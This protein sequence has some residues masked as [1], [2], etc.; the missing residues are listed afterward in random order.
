MNSKKKLMKL[1]LGLGL[2]VTSALALLPISGNTSLDI[3]NETAFQQ[4]NDYIDD[5]K[6]NDNNFWTSKYRMSLKSDWDGNK[7]PGINTDLN[8]LDSDVALY[9]LDNR[10]DMTALPFGWSVKDSNN[11][12]DVNSWWKRADVQS[13]KTSKRF[14]ARFNQWNESKNGNYFSSAIYFS[15]DMVLTGTVTISLRSIDNPDVIYDRVSRNIHETYVTDN[16]NINPYMSG[17]Y[18][19]SSKSLPTDRPTLRESH[20]VQNY[21]QIPNI[22]P[23]QYDRKNNSFNLPL[24]H[25]RYANKSE[26]GI[27]HKFLDW[28]GSVTWYDKNN[29]GSN[30]TQGSED[31]SGWGPISKDGGAA[32][33]MFTD[34]GGEYLKYFLEVEFELKPNIYFDGTVSS[35]F[36]S[37]GQSFLGLGTT[38]REKGWWGD[39]FWASGLIRHSQRTQSTNLKY[40]TRESMANNEYVQDTDIIPQSTFKLFRT[41]NKDAGQVVIDRSNLFKADTPL[42]SKRS[43][44]TK[45]S[46]ILTGSGWSN[47][48]ISLEVSLDNPE[49]KKNW[50]AV[51]S[52]EFVPSATS[53]YMER[54]VTWDYSDYR[55]VKI[56]IEK[57]KWLTSLQKSHLTT[58]LEKQVDQDYN[59]PG[60]TGKRNLNEWIAYVKTYNDLQ[61]QIEEKFFETVNYASSDDELTVDGYEGTK[62][63]DYLFSTSDYKNNIDSSKFSYWQ[64]AA[65]KSDD[66][67]RSEKLF[68]RSN[69]PITVNYRNLE[70]TLANW[71]R[72]NLGAPN[73][74]E[75]LKALEDKINNYAVI[76]NS[77]YNKQQIKTFIKNIKTKALNN[78]V[79]IQVKDDQG[80]SSTTLANAWRNNWKYDYL[81]EVQKLEKAVILANDIYTKTKTFNQELNTIKITDLF[82]GGNSLTDKNPTNNSFVWYGETAREKFTNVN[83]PAWT[84]L[85]DQLIGSDQENNKANNV[86]ASE[87]NLLNANLK[88]NYLIG[89]KNLVSSLDNIFGNG[90]KLAEEFKQYNYIDAK[91]YYDVAN[92]DTNLKD[93]FGKISKIKVGGN[94]FGNR[95]NF[96]TNSNQEFVLLKP[97]QN[98]INNY[99]LQISNTVYKESAN[100]VKTK[101]N[102]L[103]NLSDAQKQSFNGEIDKLIDT[104]SATNKLNVVYKNDSDFTKT[105]ELAKEQDRINAIAKSLATTENKFGYDQANNQTK[106]NTLVKDA[107]LAEFYLGESL[108]DA[109]VEI[110]SITQTEQL[111]DSGSAKL[112]YVVKSTKKLYSTTIQSDETTSNWITG[113]AADRAQEKQRIDALSVTFALKTPKSVLAREITKENFTQYI[114][115]NGINDQTEE[116]VLKDKSFVVNDKTGTLKFDYVIR[117]KRINGLETDKIQETVNNFKTEVDRLNDVVAKIKN[118]TLTVTNNSINDKAN[119]LPSEV[120]DNEI[121]FADINNQNA[122]VKIID[123]T[124]NDDNGTLTI[125]YALT[126]TVEGLKVVQS[127]EQNSLTVNGFLTTLEKKRREVLQLINDSK[128]LNEKEKT[129]F[130]NKTNESTQT[131]QSLDELATKV[132][133]HDLSNTVKTTYTNLNNNQVEDIINKMREK[134]V[135]DDA[136]LL[137]NDASELDDAMSELHD[138]VLEQLKVLTNN[139]NI[140]DDQDNSAKTAIN[141]TLADTDKNKNYNDALLKAQNLL[142]KTSGENKDLATINT[143]IQNLTNTYNELNGEANKQKFFKTV[144][145]QT[146]LSEAQKNDY[147]TLIVNS[148][149]F[150]DANAYTNITISLN[151]AYQKL[152]DKIA[153]TKR[154]KSD[155]LYSEDTEERQKNFDAAIKA[156]EDFLTGLK[157]TRITKENEANFSSESKAKIETKIKELESA[158]SNLDGYRNK[159]KKAIDNSLYLTNVENYKDKI[160]REFPTYPNKPT[161]EQWS[162]LLGEAFN[163]SK[164]NVKNKIV[165]YNLLTTTEKNSLKGQVNSQSINTTA[166]KHF[167]ENLTSVLNTAAE[168]QKIKKDAID[169]IDNLSNLTQNQKNSFIETIKQQDSANANATKLQAEQLNQ[170]IADAKTVIL[171]EAKVLTQNDQ[172]T[173]EN[174]SGAEKTASLYKFAD[175]DKKQDYDQKVTALI[176]QMG[177][178]NASV[179]NINNAKTNLIA[180]YNALNGQ[181]NL[182]TQNTEINKLKKLSPKQKLAIKDK[183]AKSVN[184]TDLE[185]IVNK[186][187]TLDGKIAALEAKIAGAEAKKTDGIYTKDTEG[188]QAAFDQAIA[189]AESALNRY[190]TKDLA[191]LGASELNAQSVAIISDIDTLDSE[192]NKLDGYKNELKKSL[193]NWELLTETKIKELQ[194]KVDGISEKQPSEET[195]ERIL[196]EGLS[197]SKQKAK[198]DLNVDNYPNL[199]TAELTKLNEAVDSAKLDKTADHKYDSAVKAVLDNAKTQNDTK[200]NAINEINKLNFLTSDQKQVFVKKVKDNTSDQANNIL[201]EAKGINDAIRDAQKAVID[202]INELTFSDLTFE[203]AKTAK[204]T[205]DKYRLSSDKAKQDFDN[206][207]G[208]IYELVV[209]TTA[210]KEQINSAKST[211]ES[212]FAA[213]DGHLKSNEQKQVINNLSNLSEDQKKAL[214][215]KI[216]NATTVDEANAI[217]EAAKNLDKA[218]ADLKAKIAEA[219]GKKDKI[220]YTGDTTANQGKFNQAIQDAKSALDTYETVDL[221][222]LTKDQITEKAGEINTQTS[223]LNDAIGALDGYRNKFKE[224]LNNWELLDAS[225][226]KT[227]QDKVDKLQKQPTQEEKSSILQEGLSLSKSKASNKINKNNYANLS[228]EEITELL[229]KV[230][231][232]SLDETQSH[233]YDAAVKAVIKEAE[234]LNQNK[235]AAINA[236]N[237]LSDLTKN[238]K[239]VFENQVK[240]L[241]TSQASTVQETA[242]TLN[243]AILEAKNVVKEQ[244]QKLAK[245]DQLTYE[246]AKSANKVADKYRLADTALKQTYDEKLQAL[247]NLITKGNVSKTEIDN[248]KGEL[249]SAYDALNGESKAK[250]KKD[251]IDDLDNLT[252]D[253]KQALKDKIDSS[254]NQEEANKIIEVAKN[255][256]KAITDLKAKITEA[257][258]KKNDSEY[259]NDTAENKAKFDEAI[260]TAK[261]ALKSYETADLSNLNKDQIAEKTGE[262]NT[263]TS[264]LN[265]AI[266]ALDGYRNK[267]KEDLNNWAL[268]EQEDVKKLQDKVAQLDKQPTTEQKAALLKEGLD[269]SKEIATNKINKTNYGNLSDTEINDLL[270]KVKNAALDETADH[271]FDANVNDIVLKADDLQQTKAN[272]ISAIENLSDLTAEQKAE[273]TKQIKATPVSQASTIQNTANE[274]NE[275]I[276]QA[277]EAVTNQIKVLANNNQL[278]YETAKSANKVADKY[279]LADS[280]LKATY[281]EKLQALNDLIVKDNVPKTEIDNAKA[282]LVTAYEA[283][284]GN[285]KAKE[286]K[287]AIKKLNNLTLKQKE[288]LKEKIDNASDQETA[289]QI[290]EKAK[291]LDQ[292][293]SDLKT[294]L[295]EAKNTKEQPV[296]LN[297]TTTNKEALDNQITATEKLL[298]DLESFDLATN[299]NDQIIAKTTEVKKQKES[300]NTAI[301]N[302]DGK[303][304]AL[305]NEINAYAPELLDNKQDY[306]DRIN[307]LDKNNWDEEAAN[308]ILNNSLNKAKENAQNQIDALTN[309]T[310]EEKAAFKQQI[311]DAQKSASNQPVSNISAILNEAKAQNNTKQAAIDHIKGLNNLNDDQKAALVQEVKAAASSEAETLKTK[312]NELNT[313]MKNT[314][315]KVL[316]ELQTLTE[317]S[318]LEL[319]D[320]AYSADKTLDNYQ[321]ASS[322]VKVNYDAKLAKIKELLSQNTDK[323]TIDQA[324]KELE[325]AYNALNGEENKNKKAAEVDKLDNLSK[326][327]KDKIKDLLSN[328]TD[329]EAA[330]KIL[331]KAQKLNLDLGD[332]EKQ[333]T[334]TKAKVAT[335]IYTNDAQDRKEAVDQALKNAKDK[336]AELKAKDLSNATADS[337]NGLANEANQSKEALKTA[338]EALDGN[339]EVL[340]NDIN[341]HFPSLN[342]NQKGLLKAEIEK[343]PK[344]PTQEETQAVYDKALKYAQTNAKDELAKLDNLTKAEKDTYIAKIEATTLDKTNEDFAINVKNLLDQA[345]TDETAKAQAIKTINNLTNLNP[346]QKSSLTEE[347]KNNQASE[348]NNIVEKAKAI[349]NKMKAYK[350]IAEVDKT[351]VDYVEADEDRQVKYNNQVAIRAED[352]GDNG[353]NL[354]VEQIDTKITELNNAI[355]GLNGEEKV[356][357]AKENAIAKING[358]NSIYTNLTAQQKDEAI[359]KINEQNSVADVNSVD[360]NNA[361]VNGTMATL[362]QYLSNET[363]IKSD[364]NYTGSEEDLR[365]AYDD[366]IKALKDYESALNEPSDDTKD[367]LNN[368]KIAE[369]INVV[370]EAINNLNGKEH[371]KTVR[372]EEIAKINA[373]KNINDAQKSALIAKVDKATTPE[374]VRAVTEEAQALDEKMAELKQAVADK[375]DTPNSVDYKNATE[376]KMREFDKAFNNASNLADKE[377]GSAELSI[378]NIDSLI[379]KLNV[380]AQNLDGD[381][382]I[383]NK[384]AEAKNVINSLEHLNDAQKTALIEEVDKAKLLANVDKVVDK[385]QTL[386]NAMGQLKETAKAI[387]DELTQP[388]NP[389]YVAASQE[390]KANY[391]EAKTKVDQLISKQGSNE[392]VA[393]VLELEKAL[394]DA[395]NALDG[396]KNFEYAK[397]KAI[398]KVNKN[399]NLSPAEKQVLIDQV[400]DLAIPSNSDNADEVQN[401]KDNLDK[402]VNKTNLINDVKNNPNLTLE[403]KADLIDDIQKANVDDKLNKE[404]NKN[405]Y[406]D[407]LDNI[408]AK[409]TAYER[410]NATDDS[411]LNTEDKA[412]LSDNI[413]QLDPR[414]KTFADQLA[415]E[416][417]KENKIKEIRSNP[418]LT[419]DQKSQLIDEVANLDNKQDDLE[420][421]IANIDQKAK[422]IEKIQTNEHISDEDK[423]KLVNEVINVPHDDSKLTDK[424]N[425]IES[426]L[427]LIDQIKQNPKLDENTKEALIDQVH[428]LAKDSDNFATEADNISAKVKAIEQIKAN[429][430]LTKENKA[431]LVNEIIDLDNNQTKSSLDH[432]IS[433]VD[434]KAA[435]YEQINQSDLPQAQKDALIAELDPINANSENALVS[436]DNIKDQLNKLSKINN[437]QSLSDNDKAKLV[438]DVLA[439]N[440]TEQNYNEIA[441]NID[442]KQEAIDQIRQN[443][444]LTQEQKDSISQNIRELDETSE[445]FT[446]KLDNEKARL[447]LIDQLHQEA[448]DNK[449]SDE[450]RDKLIS[451]TLNLAND[452]SFVNNLNNVKTKDKLIQQVKESD[453][454]NDTTKSTLINNILDN[455]ATS[456]EF[457]NKHNQITQLYVDAEELAKAKNDLV[458]LTKSKKFEKLTKAKQDAIN[459]AITDSDEIL[460]NLNSHNNEDVVKQTTIDKRLKEASPILI[461][462]YIVAVSAVTWLI[463]M[464]IFV[465]GRK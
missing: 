101:I 333:I 445:E 351:S 357:Q 452:S 319:N 14:I 77:E 261:K 293:I 340:R 266:V 184:L 453:M 428:N 54:S 61:K 397:E 359:A 85:M 412:K 463:G 450:T 36:N 258:S 25:N 234:Q 457:D 148:Q 253:Q 6:Y 289:N 382:K 402:I 437:D 158:V 179:D 440:P 193:K 350:D 33:F 80:Q 327:Q 414:D 322:D 278:T 17:T 291:Q 159:L 349:D 195:K 190:K 449:I 379:E 139:Q 44:N 354:S 287:S 446:N 267:F 176:N 233:K 75:N 56:E 393:K 356:D 244:I 269:K 300:L 248:A 334:S 384:K 70:L 197:L 201:E 390:P 301:T 68:D 392:D 224:D 13:N 369:K 213:L 324:L 345:K 86:F 212:A 40:I 419:D 372:A 64:Y 7:Y 247:N 363:K 65:Y 380:A 20:Y 241:P 304:E 407:T 292:A 130:R 112:T 417:L 174:V 229:R 146:N 275:A 404:A 235:Q 396:D 43:F 41:D 296:Y 317:N 360:A 113:F 352:L 312:A 353:T 251:V 136:Q 375:Q 133:I 196:G 210:T 53:G 316:E 285:E 115:V 122:K 62:K 74:L 182:D 464:L 105:L 45:N 305:R 47:R 220:E 192:I 84:K 134:T 205:A 15:R 81:G 203:Q 106:S 442:K 116:I 286:Q 378:E 48:N 71:N 252:P 204:K 198:S 202:E 225:E 310:N 365:K 441:K 308:A 145:S 256:D 183:M 138:K 83:E 120:K 254:T 142:N 72:V 111:T 370:H 97:Y 226:I 200:Q 141:Y 132:K 21:Q 98:D 206:A 108:T 207:M 110:K 438:E 239:T 376:V 279:R 455:N 284:N 22:F 383:N 8:S 73:G 421:Q 186:A 160:E 444:N 215:D 272:A 342:E 331:E 302:L 447:D 433:N 413:S 35:D 5:N 368:N 355:N 448:K 219:E 274:L 238:Q 338:D 257:E 82:T 178:H 87:T 63:L 228:S 358:E 163:E 398:E 395:K 245:D 381:E 230:N 346:A 31:N 96:A 321:F 19:S 91:K 191:N 343:L 199:S 435:L 150:N 24:V 458:D 262:I 223:T 78:F 387:N 265:D 167:D 231:S 100:V 462:P 259:I 168:K 38:I 332:L 107:Q 315:D 185:D 67:N 217:V 337:L 288:Q 218:I 37:G 313:S 227:L 125:N 95:H 264:T 194:T 371:I 149:N 386:N 131:I 188:K 34:K 298:K 222:N 391:D 388:D 330:Q 60:G 216:D 416:E 328:A 66:F 166:S 281:D 325:K 366:A 18:R 173:Y 94:Q 26:Y 128:N 10:G 23:S 11:S 51:F 399:N 32:L 361:L 90:G 162:Q 28:E 117:S 409:E 432:Q 4:I 3:S 9:E 460:N 294:K 299:S 270:E 283:L 214:K 335:S 161:D 170:A 119:R 59:L 461:W 165:S 55:K 364:I 2:P 246:T 172:L 454:L 16:A 169:A 242:T 373:L 240:S 424:L 127:T 427:N 459:K 156:A 109:T 69:A 326:D 336:L 181:T 180:A 152:V 243:T 389:K 237:G 443:P 451:E 273:F 422:L 92:E 189:N 114:N 311:N 401:F 211:L 423:N 436:F 429:D 341:N 209:S 104:N 367:I 154:V 30:A 129:E 403:Q 155:E 260:K 50:K 408:K 282:A 29:P 374:D 456:T 415:N 79:N 88:Q 303:R 307:Q 103:Q 144:D 151:N 1:A 143:I 314:K 263:Q 89:F 153:E 57:A 255:L 434:K 277:K 420:N 76:A 348:A 39:K 290:I 27:G 400:K 135:F 249:I 49:D 118:N 411:Q 157:N 102:D 425:N 347:I 52:P 465:F 175:N 406:G 171:N 320:D 377:N 268:L 177:L 271:K 405:S 236:I 418:N 297:D 147:K 221:S 306:L 164:G 123:I 329:E 140:T 362:G 124:K 385:A 426:K 121:T 280:S 276:K 187:Q 12:S 46:A 318:N 295:N 58:E 323:A 137:F 232:A 430:E 93:W 431:N 344:V 99:L 309:L 126:S 339:R 208:K 394:I 410:I 250:D 42:A 439:N